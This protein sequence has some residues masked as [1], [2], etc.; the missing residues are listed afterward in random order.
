MPEQRSDGA[1]LAKRSLA[2]NF[3][4]WLAHHKYS[5][6][7]TLA[8]LVADKAQTL[9][10]SLVVAIALAL[11]ALLFLAL[12]NLQQL[13]HSWDTE[14]KLTL[15][16]HERASEVAID[17]LLVKLRGDARIAELRYIDADTALREFEALSGFGSVLEGLEQNPLPAAVELSPAYGFQS[18]EAQRLLA[19]EL[20]VLPLVAE[21]DI[22][23]AWVQR[24]L[25]ITELLRQVVWF[26]ALLLALGALLAIGNTVRLIIE[27][28]KDEIVIIKLVGG[29][30]GFVRRPLLYTGGLYGFFGA[31]LA[32]LLLVLVSLLSAAKVESIAQAYNSSFSLQGLSLVQVLQLLGLGTALGWLGA[33]IAVG[34]H[35]SKIEPS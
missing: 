13:G 5:F 12:L 22:D 31:L 16:L 15:Y 8:R 4:A 23:L 24:F 27:N 14:P 10:T 18:A 26:L 1:S 32:L 3:S 35:L 6:R 30:N 29:T 20:A 17:K 2:D 9:L 25:A 21:A 34:R 7:S 11:P 28:R 19:Q 33:V